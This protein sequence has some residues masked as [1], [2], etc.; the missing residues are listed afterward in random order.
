[1]N[2]GEGFFSSC[3]FDRRHFV[4]GALKAVEVALS[5]LGVRYFDL[6]LL[7]GVERGGEGPALS[8]GELRFYLPIFVGDKGIYLLLTVDYQPDRN[9]LHSAC[10]E[11]APYLLR[12]KRAE[13][14]AHEAIEDTPC[15]LSVDKVEVDLLR[16]RHAVCDAC[17]G[18]FV[19]G[20]SVLA[21][22]VKAEHRRQMP[23][24][25]FPLAVGVGCEIDCVAGG[26]F[27]LKL[28]DELFFPLDEGIFRSE[29]V[30]DV[31]A[32]LRCGQIPDM[33]LGGNDVVVLAEIFLDSVRLGGRLNYNEL[34][35]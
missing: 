3:P 34:R 24:Y 14:V 1:M 23:R 31:N 11:A 12:H 16:V 2:G 32:E 28:L 9:A 6:A 8:V 33:T 21:L 26:D 17:L 7:I 22:E 15:L 30:F 5:L 19:E 10:G 25:R 27:I 13:A 29:A 20:D 35:H 18:Y 4:F